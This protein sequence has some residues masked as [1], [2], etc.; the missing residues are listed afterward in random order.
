VERIYRDNRIFRIFEGT[1]EINRMLITGMLLR[2]ALK[3]EIPLFAEAEKVKSELPALE[4]VAPAPDDGPLGYQRRLVERSKKIFLYLCGSAAQKYGMSI[5]DEQEVLG[6]LADIAQEVF[7][8]ES[9]LLRALKSIESTGEQQ[10]K[11]KIDMM[12]LY[13]NGAMARVGDYAA[14]LLAVM[15]TGEALDSQ[16]EMLRKASQFT[17]LNAVQLRREIADEVTEVGRFTC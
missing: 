12:Q 4:P 7:A 14:Q 1:N 8:M 10:A 9:G 17:P 2:N 5:E 13:V 3:N 15:E 6:Q 16:L 11:T